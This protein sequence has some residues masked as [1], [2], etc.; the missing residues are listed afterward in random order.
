MTNILHL[1]CSARDDGSVTRELS[2]IARDALK[3]KH[4]G[5]NTVYR[6][7]ARDPLPHIGSTAATAFFV[8][9]DERTEAHRAALAL[10]DSMTDE[11]IDADYIVAGIPMYNF[12]V[13]S[14]FKAWIDHVVRPRKTFRRIA[15]GQLEGL[16]QGKI[17][18]ACI[19]SNGQFTAGA[20]DYLRPYLKAM[21][22]DFLLFDDVVYFDAERMAYGPEEKQASIDQA[23]K[24][25]NAYFS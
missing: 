14:S 8:A 15:N 21:F 12:T 19:A 22:K 3:K 17:M 16:C 7:L 18:V 1:D 2:T 13:P 9:D 6:D 4:P 23:A 10:S 11:L 25:I 24:E 20:F 5:A